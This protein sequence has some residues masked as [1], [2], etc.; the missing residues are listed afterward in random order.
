MAIGLDE[1]FK[2]GYNY[3]EFEPGNIP[4]LFDKID[5][6]LSMDDEDYHDLSERL[7][8]SMENQHYHARVGKTLGILEDV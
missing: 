2:D 4:D 8:K 7:V 3:F 1:F 6:I 5:Y